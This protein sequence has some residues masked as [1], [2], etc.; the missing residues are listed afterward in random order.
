MGKGRRGER[1]EGEKGEERKLDT[2][3]IVEDGD[4]NRHAQN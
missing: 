3:T 2:Q 1:Q 4:M